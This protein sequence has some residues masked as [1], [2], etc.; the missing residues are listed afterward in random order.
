MRS[1][2]ELEEPD[3]SAGQQQPQVIQVAGEVE[4]EDI[5][6]EED[7]DVGADNDINDE[8]DEIEAELVNLDEGFDEENDIATINAALDNISD[9]LDKLEEQNDQLNAQLR[10][11]GAAHQRI[12]NGIAYQNQTPQAPSDRQDSSNNSSSSSRSSG[13][14]SSGGGGGRCGNT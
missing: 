8:D 1:D 7:M 13:G 6:D 5:N 2:R 3:N 12:K 14:A 9:A 4:Q 11:L 10:S